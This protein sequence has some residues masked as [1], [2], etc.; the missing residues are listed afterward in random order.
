M[1]YAIIHKPHGR[2]GG[3]LVDRKECIKD[4]RNIAK[5][6]NVSPARLEKVFKDCGC[7]VFNPKWKRFV[8]I[9]T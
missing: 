6:F 9:H 4:F 1:K 5:F 8:R 7:N 3:V 2:P